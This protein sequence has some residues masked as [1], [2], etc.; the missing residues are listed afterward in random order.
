METG[1]KYFQFIEWSPFWRFSSTVRPCVWILGSRT[2]IIVPV[3]V[4]QGVFAIVEMGDLG[5]REAVLS[6]PQHSLGGHRLRVRPREQKE[7]QSPASRSPKRVAPDSLQ[8]IKA[9]AE[10]PDVEAQMVKLVGLR[11]LSE[12]ER[13]LRSLVVA[14]MQEVFTE[15][16]PGEP[17]PCCV[18]IPSLPQLVVFTGLLFHLCAELRSSPTYSLQC[19]LTFILFSAP[20]LCGPSFWLLHKQL[21]RPWLWPWPLPGSGG[22]GRA[23][24]MW[25]WR[26]LWRVSGNG[27]V[28][29]GEPL[30]SHALVPGL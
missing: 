8:L 4:W 12:A 24:G 30:T 9:L 25:P 20:R 29:L 14:L 6:Q 17:P 7:F 21:W 11:E 23:P 26:H 16:F 2:V 27:R 19:L 15:F 10:A 3:V 1:S 5:A 13:Q 18:C 22:L 28:T